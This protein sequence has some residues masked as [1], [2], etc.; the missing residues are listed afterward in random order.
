MTI[1]QKAAWHEKVSH[2]AAQMDAAERNRVLKEARKEKASAEGTSEQKTRL[3][4]MEMMLALRAAAEEK[5]S[6]EEQGTGFDYIRERNPPTPAVPV[7]KTQDE[8]KT[9]VKKATAK[10]IAQKIAQKV[11][12]KVQKKKAEEAEEAEDEKKTAVKKA[13]AKKIAQKIAQKVAEKVQK[14]KAEEAEAKKKADKEKADKKQK[15]FLAFIKDW[16]VF[17]SN[18]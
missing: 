14:K 2:R 16:G 3:T 18:K 9:A 10:K 4:P 12:E 17:P 8:K 5:L 7:E 11:A 6:E 13:T 15:D 1:A